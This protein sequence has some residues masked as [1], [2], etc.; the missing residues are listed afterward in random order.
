V[1]VLQTGVYSTL[2]QL[3][4]DLNLVFENAKQYNADESV[5]YKVTSHSK[6]RR[7]IGADAAFLYFDTLICNLL[8]IT[9]KHNLI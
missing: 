8:L 7:L 3:Y 6:H 1:L 9:L 4:A 5:I 2:D